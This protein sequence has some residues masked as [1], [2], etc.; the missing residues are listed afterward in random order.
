MEY[1]KKKIH[2][3]NHFKISN[4]NDKQVLDKIQSLSHDDNN[5]KKYVNKNSHHLINEDY[6]SE[7]I[8]ITSINNSDIDKNISIDN[9][10]KEEN[11]TKNHYHEIF[12]DDN[13]IYNEKFR[14]IYYIGI[15][16]ILTNYDT[17]KKCEYCYKS[18]RYCSN[19]MSCISPVKYQQRF[20]NYLKKII[21]PNDQTDKFKINTFDENKIKKMNIDKKFSLYTEDLLSSRNKSEFI[22]NK[23]EKIF[24][25][26]IH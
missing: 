20:I 18:I 19:N 4:N 13:G 1:I 8:S 25:N 24:D 9:I 26:I 3:Q 11:K 5:N 2:N 7:S 14:E 16:D 10:N 6:T 22:L 12:L 15:I 21:I 17:F 23:S